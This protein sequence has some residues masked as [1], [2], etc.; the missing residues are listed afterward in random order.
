[1]KYIIMCD[2]KPTKCEDCMF[3]GDIFTK[4]DTV[5]G[6]PVKNAFELSLGCKLCASSINDCPLTVINTMFTDE[7]GGK[8]WFVNSVEM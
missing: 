3:F 4:T 2:E 8:Q 5:N 7:E 1:M 6:L